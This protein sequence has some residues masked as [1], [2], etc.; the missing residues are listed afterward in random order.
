MKEIHGSAFFF[1]YV[2]SKASRI[3]TSKL[4][5]AFGAIQKNHFASCLSLADS[6]ECQTNNGGCEHRCI[7]TNG[8]YQCAC[9]KG[10][11]LKDDKVK[12]EGA[13]RLRKNFNTFYQATE[14]PKGILCN[15]EGDF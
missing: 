10:Y 4:F 15:F 13:E 9:N 12:C 1:E 14:F 2:K 11:F 6:D 3:R 7:N 8:S 5:H